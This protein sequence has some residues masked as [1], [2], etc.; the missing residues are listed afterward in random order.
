MESNI[1][2]KMY[3]TFE[4]Y[5]HSAVIYEK[6]VD[7]KGFGRI[8]SKGDKALF[9][10]STSEMKDKLGMP[11]KRALADF[12]PAI[13]IKAKDFA[14]EITA[15][16]VKEHNL[17]NEV[18]ITDEH[19]KKNKDVRK[20]LTDRNIYPEKLPPEEDIKKIERRL[21]SEDKKLSKNVQKIEFS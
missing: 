6:G 18:K 12:L 5:V 21:S 13:T 15:F 14:N 1:V 20:V 16:N 7:E 4:D 19:V 3:K 2:E 8:K 9:N 11:Q 17:N 10:Y